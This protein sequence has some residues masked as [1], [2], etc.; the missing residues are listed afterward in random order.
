[1]PFMPTTLF[2]HPICLEH[3]MGE[4]HPECPD[5]LRVVMQALER[6]EF[7]YLLRREAPLAERE[8]LERVHDPRYVADI[9]DHA[10]THGHRHLDADTA[11]CPAT[12]EAALRAAGAVCAAVDSVM[13]GEARNAFCA[14][15]PP[16]HHAERDRA[17]G[18]CFF[19]NVAVGAWHAR[20][21]HGIRRVAVVD[22]D[23][24]HG[25]GTQHEFWEEGSLFYASSHQWPAYPGTGQ[26]HEHG[27]AGNIVNV[28]LPPGSGSDTF[29][30]AYSDVILPSLTN[31]KP[32][33]L[34][35]S[36]GFDAHIADPLAHLRVKTE[37]FGW[38]TEELLKVA[39][40][41]CQGRVV[42][43]LEGGYDLAALSASV[44]AHVR[45][46]MGH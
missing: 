25:N 22:F 12:A 46:L 15:R 19:N 35:I 41:C 10:P 8:T 14:V 39:D 7:C 24:H 45:A 23:V 3:E 26:E 21:R 34:I 20:A 42:S 13:T 32:E 29:R 2:T 28:A 11:M 18:F 1:M 5:R 36:A 6:Q 31:F 40:V 9:L 37:D 4:Y 27:V 33:L 43:S 17:M 16:G 30:K 44:A 38:V